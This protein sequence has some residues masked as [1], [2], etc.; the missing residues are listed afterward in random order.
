MAIFLVF[1][2]T[3]GTGKHFVEICLARG[4]QVRALARIPEKLSPRENLQITQG[5]ISE[6]EKFED[7]VKGVD[8][9]V[10]FLGDGKAQQVA[11]I[12][13]TF[14]KQLIPVMRKHNVKRF[15]YQAGALTSHYETPLPAYLWVVRHTLASSMNGQHL[16]NEGVI[17]YLY[18]DCP[19]IEWIVH[20]AA[21]LSSGPSKGTL[22]RSATKIGIGSFVDAAMYSF[23]IVQDASAVHTCDLS[24]Y[25]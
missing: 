19:D 24:T 7:L 9:I 3:G 8:Y 21:I 22:K 10:C 1:G 4:H 16:D 17:H 23:V 14:C 2:A 5:S 18:K 15:L 20:R 6:T 13:T 25:E 12:N 11:K